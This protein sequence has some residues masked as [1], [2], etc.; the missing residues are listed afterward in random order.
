MMS[1]IVSGAAIVLAGYFLGAI[2]FGFLVT[3]W[4]RGIDIRRY[5]SGSTGTTNVLRVMGWKWS[6]FVFLGDL[7]KSILPVLIARILTGDAWIESATGVAVIAGHC[8]SIFAGWTGGKGSTS[9]FGALLVLQPFAAIGSFVVAML[10][11]GVTRYASLGS[12]LGT[13]FGTLVMVVLVATH[14]VPPGDIV[15][16]IGSPLIVYLRH[17]ENIHRLIAGRERKIGSTRGLGP[18]Q[19]TT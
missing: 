13:A 2:P 1:A 11:M 15:F 10:V 3:R 7:V 12:L 9:S 16:I 4:Q 5:G 18:N 14:G 19:V 6:A 17:W 8:W